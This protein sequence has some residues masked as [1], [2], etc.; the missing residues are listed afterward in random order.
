[1][2]HEKENSHILLVDDELSV[3]MFLQEWLGL[4]D[5]T[6]TAFQDSEQALQAFIDNSQ[7]YD[8]VL[9]DHSMPKLDGLCLAKEICKIHQDIPIIM[10]SGYS[11]TIDVHQA[12]AIHL[13]DKPFETQKLLLLINQLISQPYVLQ[14]ASH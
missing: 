10:A 7:Q 11:D 3:L 6:V 9:T 2:N 4:H 8:L 1:M 14:A 13:I 12:P 5:F